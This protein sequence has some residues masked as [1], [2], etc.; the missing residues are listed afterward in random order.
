MITLGLLL[1][2]ASQTICVEQTYKKHQETV[3]QCAS[4]VSYCQEASKGW[5]ARQPW[6]LPMHKAKKPKHTEAFLEDEWYACRLHVTWD[7]TG[8]VLLASWGTPGNFESASTSRNVSIEHVTVYLCL[9]GLRPSIETKQ[10][11][12]CLGMGQ[13]LIIPKMDGL[14]LKMTNT[15]GLLVPP[16]SSHTHVQI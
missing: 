9:Q 5:F 7:W 1:H 3:I 14:L 4:N 2:R 11:S 13:T 12:M 6:H 8:H 15:I 16:I 10:K